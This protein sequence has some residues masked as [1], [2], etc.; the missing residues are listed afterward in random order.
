MCVVHQE[1]YSDRGWEG[2]GIR[3]SSRTHFFRCVFEFYRLLH[4]GSQQQLPALPDPQPTLRNRN[5]DSGQLRKY[6]RMLPTPRLSPLGREN[7]QKWR[8]GGILGKK[9]PKI[10]F[11]Y[12]PSV[13]KKFFKSPRK[14][15]S[16]KYF[17]IFSIF[18]GFLVKK[19]FR[20]FMENVFTHPMSRSWGGSYQPLVRAHRR[21]LDDSYFD[22][23]ES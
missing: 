14:K 8:F 10:G 2:S 11:N 5:R 18:F 20:G 21:I 1:N 16:K 6:C 19:W 4:A 15:F 17:F 13:K 9:G 3:I 23:I 22:C 12:E 7:S